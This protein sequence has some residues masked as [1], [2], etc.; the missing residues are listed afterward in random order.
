MRKVEMAAGAIA[1]VLIAWDLATSLGERLAET[2]GLCVFA[3]LA[4]VPSLYA[5]GWK[6]FLGRLWSA[7]SSYSPYACA[8][9]L[10]LSHFILKSQPGSAAVL[11]ILYLILLIALIETLQWAAYT[12]SFSMSSGLSKA[13]WAWTKSFSGRF[14]PLFA[15]GVGLSLL[16]IVT[17]AGFT[18]VWTVLALAVLF[19]VIIVM[20]A[21]TAA[22]A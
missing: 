19:F 9:A 18:G 11:S 4:I 10:G 20:T 16:S 7:V 2:I 13:N 3:G 15:L 21:K 22:R 5:P 17:A 14:L 6:G 1:S 8:G 12:K